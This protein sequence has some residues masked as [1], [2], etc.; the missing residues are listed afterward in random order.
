MTI[1]VREWVKL[2]TTAKEQG[3]TNGERAWVEAVNADGMGGL[4]LKTVS[5]KQ[6]AMDKQQVLPLDY[7]YASTGHSAQGLGAKRVL[8]EKESS[9]ITTNQRSFYTDLTRA[10]EEVRLYT[11]DAKA[12]PYAITRQVEKTTALEVTVPRQERELER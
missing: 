8:M 3:Y 2:T 4:V 7:A 6:I 5:G 9:S 1:A 10:K 11:N 12:L